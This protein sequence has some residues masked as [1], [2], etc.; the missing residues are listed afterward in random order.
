MDESKPVIPESLLKGAL[1][2]MLFVYPQALTAKHAAEALGLDEL[3]VDVAF[4][5]LRL[6]YAERGLQIA[7]VAGGYQMCTRPE[8]VD[9]I[10]ALLKP[11]RN[12]LSRAALETVAI[13]AYKQPITQPE[14]DAVRGVNSDGVVRTLLERRL[15][16]QVGRRES[17]GR[18]I[19][20]AT[21]AEFLSHFG[22]SDLTDLPELSDVDLPVP[23]VE[24]TDEAAAQGTEK[25]P[26][27]S[28]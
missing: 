4:H 18:P 25:E 7:R 2:C 13:I 15:V 19:L 9:Q 6:D 1:E 28:E 11:E 5:E 17:P 26:E 3:A 24:P 23:D 12:R 20:Y 21:S 10:S 14:I 22:L 16:K 8:F 27:G